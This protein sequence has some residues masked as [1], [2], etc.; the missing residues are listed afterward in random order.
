MQ[1]VR[2]CPDLIAESLGLIIIALSSQNALKMFQY[3]EQG[4]RTCVD[5]CRRPISVFP[6]VAK[7]F[8]RIMYDQVFLYI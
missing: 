4:K 5:N 8:E 1:S 7:V 6:A 3:L 2:E